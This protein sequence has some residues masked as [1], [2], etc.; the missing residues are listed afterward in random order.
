MFK[1]HKHSAG[2]L[3]GLLFETEDRDNALLR[4]T[5]EILP[6]LKPEKIIPFI[7]TAI[8]ASNP[9]CRQLFLCKLFAKLIDR[10][11]Y[12]ITICSNAS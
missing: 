11:V 3:L 9:T 12:N 7:A 8:R 4:N 2:C 10:A 1:P 6:K 5:N